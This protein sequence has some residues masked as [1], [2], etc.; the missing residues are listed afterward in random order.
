M[1]HIEEFEPKINKANKPKSNEVIYLKYNNGHYDILYS[2]L[3]KE[4]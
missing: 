1:E 4:I 2:K 3:F